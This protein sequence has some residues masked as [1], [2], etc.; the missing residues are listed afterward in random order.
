MLAYARERYRNIWEY[1]VTIYFPQFRERSELLS[2]R[3]GIF[4][5]TELS[6][7]PLY[8]RLDPPQIAGT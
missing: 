4:R 2:P 1:I 5:E 8:F 3:R 6:I 7:F